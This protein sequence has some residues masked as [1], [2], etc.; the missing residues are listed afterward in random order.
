MS[1]ARRRTLHRIRR[2]ALTVLVC[3]IA[4]CAPASVAT[5][6]TAD[7]VVEA[8][9][10]GHTVQARVGDALL[11]RRPMN[12]DEWQVTFDDIHI[13]YRGAPDALRTPAADGWRFTAI[14]AGDTALTVAPVLRGGANP[15][16]FTVAFHLEP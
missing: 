3:A 10:F 14:R 16:R 5:S 7:R 11:V 12:A 13:Q 8:A 9:D 6:P 15:P 4:D 1:E 2:A